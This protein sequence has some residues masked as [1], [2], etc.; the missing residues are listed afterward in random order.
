MKRAHL[1]RSQAARA[2]RTARHRPGGGPLALSSG[3]PPR[4]LQ[5]PASASQ[6]QTRQRG[7]GA[8]P[9]QP[10]ARPASCAVAA[11]ATSAG[12]AA[13]DGAG[14]RRPRG[15]PPPPQPRTRASS[16][17]LGRPLPLS[18]PVPPRSLLPAL[19]PPRL[20][21]RPHRPRTRLPL[22]PAPRTSS[23]SGPAKEKP[24]PGSRASVQHRGQGPAPLAGFLRRPVGS[25]L[26]R[27]DTS[28]GTPRAGRP[29]GYI[30]TGSASTLGSV[31]V[32]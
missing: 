1:C 13:P 10:P 11:R 12:Q 20:P 17:N 25:S 32:Q 3:K 7:P 18:R 21:E 14:R 16:A 23:S 6:S 26:R 8:A 4:A 27:A 19:G 22:L 31:R 30:P 28:E 15:F 29:G 24:S 5:Q 2:A 9:R